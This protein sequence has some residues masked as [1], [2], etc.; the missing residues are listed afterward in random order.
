MADT[1]ARYR[2]ICG[3]AAEW[4]VSDIVIAEGE[5]AVES[6]RAKCYLEQLS[7]QV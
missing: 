3:T 5:I 7:T 6:G 2:H 1:Y 4:A